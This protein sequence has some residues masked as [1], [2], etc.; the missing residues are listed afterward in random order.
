MITNTEG[1]LIQHCFVFVLGPGLRFSSRVP[2]VGEL[3]CPSSSVE[4]PCVTIRILT[5]VLHGVVPSLHNM[6][7][8]SRCLVE[9]ESGA[10][11][12]RC[13][14]GGFVIRYNFRELAGWLEFA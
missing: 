14:S 8:Q 7:T 9:A 13:D 1:R 10:S 3:R 6:F 12:I 5:A 11:V 2:V 4:V